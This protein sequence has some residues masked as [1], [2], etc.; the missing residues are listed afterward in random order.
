[1]ANLLFLF[2]AVF[3]VASAAGIVLNR[4]AVNSAMCLL[5][6]LVGVAGLFVRLDA[7]LLAFVLLLVYAGAVVALFLF[8][9]MLLDAKGGTMPPRSAL[10]KAAGLV[11]FALVAAAFG[12]LLVRGRLPAPPSGTGAAIGASL[13]LYAYQLFTLYLLPVEIVGFLLLVTMIGVIVLSERQ[14]PSKP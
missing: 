5:L 6:C 12:S 1:M 13:K 14:P 11:A 2:F 4:N 3:T 7:F 10:S 9:V 8:I